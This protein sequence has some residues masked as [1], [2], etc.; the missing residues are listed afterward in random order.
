MGDVL[1]FS[2]AQSKRSNGTTVFAPK[3]D[4]EIF[5]D[6]F[7]DVT[8][9]WQRAATKN[10]LNEF[11]LSKLPSFMHGQKGTDYMSDITALSV[12]EQ[13]LEIKV[14]LFWP[15]CTSANPIGWIAGF[16]ANGGIFTTPPDMASEAAARAMNILLYLSFEYNLKSLGRS[17]VL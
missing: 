2:L 6:C 11:F 14:A 12:I 16:H 15:G 17:I 8:G 5:T 1:S 3:T 7:E 10:R 9:E 4:A 13:R